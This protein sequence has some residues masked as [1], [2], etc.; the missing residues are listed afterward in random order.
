MNHREQDDV[1]LEPERYELRAGSLYRFG[2][3]RREFFKCAGAGIIVAIALEHTAASQ[4]SGR[5]RRRTNGTGMPQELGAWIHVGENGR[6]TVYTGKA[7]MGQNIRTS[8]SQVVAE[9]LRLPVE[10]IQLVMADTAL[11]PFDM[12]TFGSRTTPT[13]APQLRKAS[14]ATREL[15]LDLAAE[16]WKVARRGLAFEAG[17]V[18]DGAHNRTLSMAEL[19]GGQDLVKIIPADVPTTPADHWKVAGT[20][21]P[22][23]DA[24]AIV[25]GSR[26]YASDINRPGMLTGKVL[27]APAFN[28]TLAA[29]DLTAAQVID[30]ATVVRDGD[31]VAAAAADSATAAKAIAAIKA[32]WKTTPQPSGKDLFSYLKDNAA[33]DG[34][35]DP[36]SKQS[37]GS[38]EKGL[39]AA[40]KKLSTSY[41]VAYI[42]HAPLEPRAA[43][44]EW[45]NGKLTVWTG[46][47]RPFG[48]REELAQAFHLAEEQVRVIVPDTGS[49]YGGKHTGEAAIEAARISK[50]AGKPVKVVWSREEEFTW[51]YFRPG[52]VIEVSSGATKDGL[53]T[54]W[55]FHNYNSGGAAIA[56]LFYEFPNQILEFHPSR[57]PLRQGSYRGL[58]ATANHFARESHLSELADTLAIDP[59]EFRLKN[60]Q[61]PRSRA[62]LEAAAGKFGWGRSKPSTG[63]GFGVAA[64]F[65]KGGYVATC[66]ELTA[67]KAAGKVRLLRVVEAFECGAVVN[68]EHL[69]NQVEGSIV[70]AIGGALFEAIEFEDGKIL[71]PRFSR[72]RVPRF[73]DIPPIEVVLLDRRDLPSAGAGETP[74]VGLAPAV[75]DAIFQATGQRLRN[76]PMRLQAASQA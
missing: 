31:F 69:K 59:V 71:N 45:E 43:V 62:V 50:A 19:A 28:A 42:A 55:E 56:P 46:S 39:E 37:H 27:R 47:Q 54:A 40:D 52:G 4:E 64:G 5:A 22:K 74:I 53:V 32:D 25:A 3:D 8:L 13:M 70:Q 12:G 49:G 26:R 15:L 10:A 16:K 21:T 76:M 60:V 73:G 63:H 23:V 72:Y 18:V 38:L 33:H 51:A 67:D 11:T 9:E 1:D 68:P 48:V 65:E 66:V 20:S 2:V 24:K 6:I 41:G 30:G 61:N 58:A 75:A 17:K 34:A 7:E 36:D 44:A 29:A 14:A 57:S 35:G